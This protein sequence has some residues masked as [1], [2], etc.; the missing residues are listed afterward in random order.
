MHRLIPSVIERQKNTRVIQFL[1]QQG[2]QVR[3]IAPICVDVNIGPTDSNVGKLVVKDGHLTIVG[4]EASE[5]L[6]TKITGD[7]SVVIMSFPRVFRTPEVN[8]A[9][10]RLPSGQLVATD[11]EF[12][13]SEEEYLALPGV[14]ARMQEELDAEVDST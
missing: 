6:T 3:Y 11:F 2:T 5:G 12:L 4:Q 7:K 1:A 14:R 8:A 9:L 13:V 10:V